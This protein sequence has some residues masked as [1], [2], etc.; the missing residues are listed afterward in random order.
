MSRAST[1]LRTITLALVAAMLPLGAGPVQ[2]AGQKFTLPEAV[3]ADVFL[4]VAGRT[5]KES[6]FVEEYWGEVFEAFHN[7]GILEDLMGMMTGAL[8]SSQQAQVDEYRTMIHD[9]ITGVDWSGL[10]AKEMVYAQ[11]MAKV[12]QQGD[13][14]SMGP[15]D[16]LWLFRGESDSVAKNEQGLKAILKTLKDEVA[17]LAPDDPM[18]METTKVEGADVTVLRIRDMQPPMSISLARKD[19]V[20]V[21]GF[22]DIANEALALMNK[23]G[24]KSLAATDRYRKAFEPLKP[25][26]SAMVFFDMQ[27]ML[28]PLRGLAEKVVAMQQGGGED[29]PVNAEM[30]EE[31][32]E[33]H[34]AAFAAY[35]AKDYKKAL[36]LTQKQYDLAPNNSLV[37]YNLAC[38]HALTG[39]KTEALQWLQKSVD[40]GFYAPNQIRK[41]EDLASLRGEEAYKAAIAAAERQS[42]RSAVAGAFSVADRV[43]SAVGIVDYIASTTYSEGY[44]VFEDSRAVLVKNASE[45]AIYPV[46]GKQKMMAKFD[47]YVPKETASFSL[48]TGP[49]L[50]SLYEFLR[51]TVKSYG[52]EGEAVLTQWEQM[53]QGLGFNVQRDVLDWVQ[54][55]SISLTLSEELG[56]ANVWM[57]KVT[58]EAK[59]KEKIGQGIAAISS[60]VQQLAAQ[61]PMLGMLRMQVSPETYEGLDGF[62]RITMAMSPAQPFVWG[63]ADGFV[64][65]GTSAEGVHAVLQTA[66]GEHPSVAKNERVMAEAVLPKGDFWSMSFTDQRRLGSQLADAVGGAS[67]GLGMAAMAIPDPQGQQMVGKLVGILGKLGPVLRKINFYRSM[68]STSTF[69]GSEWRTLKVTN[70]QPPDERNAKATN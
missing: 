15:P 14:I 68:A 10:A 56:S 21:L 36:A 44:S 40:A 25:A 54:G 38:F 2:A 35:D 24:G 42:Q 30:S 3:P 52:P 8:G 65:F 13:N 43:L 23:S 32:K 53:Q 11:R 22:G 64:I 61:Q 62:S 48:S 57:M 60:M 67:M 66:K 58:D 29:H 50:N 55:G 19:D 34:Q 46:F 9:L 27:T 20:I 17:K 39:N 12:R 63:T 4:C 26:E 51:N 47:R 49:N 33:L 1:G 59:A 69:D 18:D 37:M 45:R 7:S 28:E 41:D 31:V 70:Y 5:D 16:M 6:Q